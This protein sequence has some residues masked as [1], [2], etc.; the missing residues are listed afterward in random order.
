MR[1]IN[2]MSHRQM[3]VSKK[4]SQPPVA[5]PSKLK[6]HPAPESKITTDLDDKNKAAIA[7]KPK[8]KPKPTGKLE[9]FSKPK[10]AVKVVKKEG[11][12]AVI[13]KKEEPEVDSKKKL[14]FSKEPPKA[15][16]KA[17]SKAHSPAPSVA[18]AKDDK[19]PSVNIPCLEMV[20]TLI[21]R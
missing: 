19:E 9:F 5:G 20:S 11:K 17:P 10:A 1:L 2:Y 21:R 16:S 14:F 13:V 12:E 8:E 6:P 15:L 3:G 7:D 18:I 4:K